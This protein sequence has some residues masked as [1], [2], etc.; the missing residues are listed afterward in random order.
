MTETTDL[1]ERVSRLEGAYEH[2]AT[3][4]D[5]AALRGELKTDIAAL[6]GELKAELGELKGSIK[7]LLIAMTFILT[8]LNIGLK[9]FVP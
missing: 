5:I 6:R 7:M 8:L 9:V 3:K 1:T 2:L 4:A